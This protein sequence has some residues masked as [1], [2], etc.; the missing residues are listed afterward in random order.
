MS[1]HPETLRCIGYIGPGFNDQ[2]PFFTRLHCCL[3]QIDFY[4]CI[5]HKI[6]CR[7]FLI[8]AVKSYTCNL[9]F[10]ILIC[11]CSIRFLFTQI[12]K[13]PHRV[14]SEIN[15][16]NRNVRIILNVNPDLFSDAVVFRIDLQVK[17]IGG[18]FHG[19]RRIDLLIGSVHFNRC[20]RFRKIRCQLISSSWTAYDKHDSNNSCRESD[21]TSFFHKPIPFAGLLFIEKSIILKVLRQ[22]VLVSED[23]YNLSAKRYRIIFSVTGRFYRYNIQ[24]EKRCLFCRSPFSGQC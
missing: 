21:D 10:L 13:I 5:I 3:S 8:R 1:Y 7:Q 24:K 17:I 4:R 2:C 12:T 20:F 22:L 11:L 9:S 16:V 15:R 18:C 19:R 6:L 23:K 14:I